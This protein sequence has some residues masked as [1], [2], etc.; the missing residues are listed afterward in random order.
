MLLLTG[1]VL[2]GSVGLTE[3]DGSLQNPEVWTGRVGEL[4]QHV[5]D[6]EELQRHTEKKKH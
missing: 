6:M 2:P 3:V 1:E 5:G 4:Y